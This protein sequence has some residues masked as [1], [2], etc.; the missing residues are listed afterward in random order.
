MISTILSRTSIRH[1]TQ[2]AVSEQ[3]INTLLRSAMSAPSACNKQ[4]WHFT[5]IRSRQLLDQLADA[6][7]NAPMLRQVPLAIVVSGDMQR[8]F[9]GEGVLYW[10]EDTSAATQNILLA[11]HALGLGAVW[12]GIY[13]LSQR[14]AQVR[15]L[16]GLPEELIPMSLIP[17]GHPA[18]HP[19]PKNKW[20]DE[21]IKWL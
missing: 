12:C 16:L 18:E 10:L 9:P 13:P 4:P 15:S 2:Q 7:P 21:A 19:T 14:I 17:I 8:T 20:R 6:T 11:A 5:V 3:D 1:F